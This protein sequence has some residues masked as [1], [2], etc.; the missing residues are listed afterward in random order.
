V[1]S[2][3]SA[4]FSQGELNSLTPQELSQLIRALYQDSSHRTRFLQLLSAATGAGSHITEAHG[5][6]R[7]RHLADKANSAAANINVIQNKAISFAS[8]TI[9]HAMHKIN[10]T[11]RG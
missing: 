10:Q 7:L 5:F 11:S 8:S 3:L 4:A 9:S 1:S 2:K 6:D